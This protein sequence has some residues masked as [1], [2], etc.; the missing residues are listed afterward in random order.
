MLILQRGPAIFVEG[1]EDRGHVVKQTAQVYQQIMSTVIRPA[2]RERVC[3]LVPLPR[4]QTLPCI[5][6]L[7]VRAI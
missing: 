2:R 4:S 7:A 3:S 5:V 1:K 6:C